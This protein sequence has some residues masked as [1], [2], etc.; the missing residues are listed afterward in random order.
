MKYP[1]RRFLN[2]AVALKELEPFVKD[3]RALRTGRPSKVFAGLRPREIWANWL[4]CATISAA[5]GRDFE[6][7]T[8]PTGGDGIIRDSA[9]GNTWPTEHIY[10]PPKVEEVVDVDALVL[11]AINAKNDR[12][13]VYA[14]NRTL[15][16]FVDVAGGPWH[17]NRLANRVHNTLHFDVAWLASLH[18]VAEDGAYHYDVTC[19]HLDDQGNAPVWRVSIAPGFDG[20]RVQRIQ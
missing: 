5:E 7:T 16:V 2:L 13:A 4:L 12:G 18:G 17:P 15:V 8:D 20:W 3:C 10:V 11:A 6:F 9:T 14:E 19:L 1:V